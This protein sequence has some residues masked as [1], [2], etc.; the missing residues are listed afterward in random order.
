MKRA[1][2]LLLTLVMLPGMVAAQLKAPGVKWSDSYSFDHYNQMKIDFFAKGD[3]L[4]RTFEY[5]TWY[6]ADAMKVDGSHEG[7]EVPAGNFIVQMDAP[8]KGQDLETIFDMMTQVAIQIFGADL[9]EPM[10]NAGAF[11][12]PVGDEIKHLTLEPANETR[13]IAG[14]PCA[15]YTYTYK[16]I[17]GSVW[18][19]TGVNL[20]NDLGIFR[21][22]K[23][24][25]LHNTLSVKGFVMEMTSEDSRGG[26]TVMTTGSLNNTG[27]LTVSLPKSKMNTAINKVNY[28]TF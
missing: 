19:T 3:E 17:F 1:N 23:M 18:I 22:A 26:K 7:I 15:K 10:Y 21:A 4:M 24:G 25:A 8:G 14:Q 20:P 13:T 16:K 2:F 27:K 6:N 28:F 11:K 5:K 9:D 12:Y